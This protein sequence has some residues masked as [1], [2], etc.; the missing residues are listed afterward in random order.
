MDDLGRIV[1]PMELRKTLHLNAGDSIEIFTDN[2][3]I[4]LKKW[5]KSCIFCG[6][7][8]QER[9]ME[10]KGRNVCVECLKDLEESR[11]T[12]GK[13]GEDTK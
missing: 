13:E 2:G 8:E 7:T 11:D 12:S 1:I 10:I 6:Q 5:E 9:L 4:V 3:H